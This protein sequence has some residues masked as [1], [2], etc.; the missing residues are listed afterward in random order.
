MSAAA[1][2]Q[3]SSSAYSHLFI[4]IVLLFALLVVA[5][6][7]SPSLVTNAGA[8]QR[9]H[10][11]RTHD[12]RHLCADFHRDGRAWRRR[13]VDRAAD[14]IP[15]CH[16]GAALRDEIS[17]NAVP[18]LR[19]CDRG[20]HRL[21]AADGLHHRLCAHPA[22]HRGAQR[23]SDTFRPQ[24]DDPATPGRHGARMDELMGPGRIGSWTPVLA[25]L[26][27]ATGHG[28]SSRAP[29]STIT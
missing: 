24:P 10:R 14:R 19:L 17:R 28:S 21:P 5:V 27:V 1:E 23:L 4:P 20:G 11:G 29:P 3:S 13:P 18:V 12:S 16:H 7:R 15:E 2:R 6:I 22:H 26:I 9:A 8:R 25:I